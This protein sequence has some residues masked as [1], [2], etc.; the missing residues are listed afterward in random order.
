MEAVTLIRNGLQH[1]KEI[2]VMAASCT[3]TSTFQPG[4]Q[5]QQTAQD[6]TVQGGSQSREVPGP[7]RCR[8][9]TGVPWTGKKHHFPGNYVV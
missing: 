2:T 6:V 9:W 3:I 1:N 8:P 7:D 5:Q 4:L